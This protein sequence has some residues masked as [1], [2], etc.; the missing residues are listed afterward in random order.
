MTCYR[1]W[2]LT[3]KK[4][5]EDLTR[6]HWGCFLASEG[7]KHALQELKFTK[8]RASCDIA[9]L[10]KLDGL[11][12]TDNK[13]QTELL[14]NLLAPAGEQISLA[15]IHNEIP[16][17]P[18]SFREIIMHKIMNDIESLPNKKESG[19]ERITNKIVKISGKQLTKPLRKLFDSL[20]SLGH[21]PQC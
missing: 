17:P 2:Q 8:W 11:L 20:L 1:E 19:P 6:K 7:I 18:F 10:R 15:T 13:E 16:L 21:S 9:L 3:F 4:K 14:F 12:T 5:I